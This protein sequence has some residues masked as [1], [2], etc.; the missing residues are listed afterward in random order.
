METCGMMDSP[1]CGTQAEGLG[2]VSGGKHGVQTELFS[3]GGRERKPLKE[4]GE[5]K[6]QLHPG[7]LFPK[8]H[9]LPYED[10]HRHTHTHNYLNN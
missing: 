4:G 6:I 10:T 1:W 5:E 7:Q 2:T 8:T 3:R 9:T